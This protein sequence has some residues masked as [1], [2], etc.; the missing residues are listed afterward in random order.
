VDTVDPRIVIPIHWDD[1]TRPLDQ[2]LLPMPRF[3]DDLDVT[4]ARLAA[5][6]EPRGTRLAFL[7]PFE[8][9]PVLPV[10]PLS[11]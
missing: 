9:V 10:P 11:K 2:P 8:T 7:P 4:L 1:F 3:L 5:H 6:L